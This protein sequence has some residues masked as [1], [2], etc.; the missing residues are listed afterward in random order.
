MGKKDWYPGG[1]HVYFWGIYAQPWTNVTVQNLDHWTPENPD[2]YFPAVRAYAAEVSNRSLA[3]PNKKYMQDASYLRV[4]NITFGYSLPKQWV[5]KAGLG[6][7]YFY[8][9]GENL[10][11]KSNLKVS[12]DPEGLGGQIYPFQRTYSFGMNLNF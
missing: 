5:E 4:K 1:A 8:F 7:V 10:F 2:G 12:L 3:V 6:R 9:S 11:E